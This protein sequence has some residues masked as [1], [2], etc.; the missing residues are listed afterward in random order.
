MT[1]SQPPCGDKASPVFLLHTKE[2]LFVG[3]LDPQPEFC[4]SQPRPTPLPLTSQD[5]PAGVNRPL[6]LMCPPPPAKQQ[7]S[8]NHARYAVDLFL[9]ILLDSL[10]PSAFHKEHLIPGRG[11]LLFGTGSLN[12]PRQHKQSQK[13]RIC[14]EKCNA[15]NSKWIS[16]IMMRITMFFFCSRPFKCFSPGVKRDI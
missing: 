6:L 12:E 2:A 1:S 15:F 9:K 11:S 8:S 3:L 14:S 7:S 13:P 10:S 16:S 5:G 4:K